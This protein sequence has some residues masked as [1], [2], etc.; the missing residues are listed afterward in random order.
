MTSIRSGENEAFEKSFMVC[1]Q[2]ETGMERL[3]VKL[4]AAHMFPTIRPMEPIARRGHYI[5][6]RKWAV[7]GIREPSDG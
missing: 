7:K 2:F 5:R 1:F 4:P 3:K 6:F